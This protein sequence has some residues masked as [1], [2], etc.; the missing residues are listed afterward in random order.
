MTRRVTL[1]D[2]ARATGVSAATVSRAL[3]GDP[4][5][6]LRTQERIREAAAELDYVPNNAAR[7]LVLRSTRT[8]GLLI[9]DTTDPV[10]G[11]VA[12]GFE[13][14]AS[15]HGY[16][17]VFSSSW[18]DPAQER[19][20]LALLASQRVD[21]MAVWG[22]LERPRD[23]LAAVRPSP[24]VLIA[25]ENPLEG[26]E[27]TLGSIAADDRAGMAALVRHLLASGHRRFAY[28]SGPGVTSNRLRRE[29][30]ASMLA[31]A[32]VRRLLSFTAGGAG[33]LRARDVAARIVRA[34]PD[35]VL[36]YDD[37]LAL[38][39]IDA[40]RRLDV[41]VPDEM[42]V[43]GFD[44]I[45]FAAFSRPRLTTVAQPAEEM[46]RRAVRMLL[47]SIQDGTMPPPEVLPVQL[48][49]RESSMRRGHLP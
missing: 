19:A 24:V 28:V 43:T 21:G 49:V 46:G 23:I 15:V 20:S 41:V 47:A 3:R 35:V 22:S 36:C 39:L 9:P 4:Q 26:T 32:G 14:E 12:A 7:S 17:V 37:K 34:R 38:G 45:P 2:V 40:L 30:A 27:G 25:A 10:H 8:L 16:S 5:I 42:S 48:V 6:S 29:A 1:V 31:E 44:D 11:Q 13:R 33:W 18:T